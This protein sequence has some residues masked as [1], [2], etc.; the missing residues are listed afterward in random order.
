MVICGSVIGLL[1]FILDPFIGATSIAEAG[2]GKIN[3][4][5]FLL[6]GALLIGIFMFPHFTNDWITEMVLVMRAF[7]LLLSLGAGTTA[8]GWIR[9]F[10]T[11]TGR[12]SYPLYMTHI[13]AIWLFGNYLNARKPGPVEMYLV[14]IAVFVGVILLGYVALR[15]YDEPIRKWLTK[16]E[17]KNRKE[18]SQ[19][20]VIH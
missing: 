18:K 10:C 5:N 19:P 16:R 7:P 15:F 20:I 9:S 6:L 1:G 13:W 11:F 8:H 14:A 17:K 3:R 2:M 4:I 12:L